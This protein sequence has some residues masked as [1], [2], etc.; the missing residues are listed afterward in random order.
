[1]IVRSVRGGGVPCSPG[2]TREHLLQI[3]ALG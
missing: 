1:M 3:D 2:L